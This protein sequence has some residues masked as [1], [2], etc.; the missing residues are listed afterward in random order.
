MPS[1]WFIIQA[2]VRE[3]GFCSL[4]T[5]H[6][7]K[8]ASNMNHRKRKLGIGTSVFF[9]C[10]FS[11]IHF[12][13]FLSQALDSNQ[14]HNSVLRA[15]YQVKLLSK[16]IQDH[17]DV[18]FISTV[19]SGQGAD[20]WHKHK[21]GRFS[22]TGHGTGLLQKL[23]FLILFPSILSPTYHWSNASN[24]IWAQPNMDDHN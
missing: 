17:Y 12:L 2:D 5:K 16:T 24:F 15:S 20:E 8:K 7:L 3:V 21:M 11:S 14:A 1:Y 19:A 22:P 6:T 18:M 23:Y 4:P 13:F 9:V 10:V